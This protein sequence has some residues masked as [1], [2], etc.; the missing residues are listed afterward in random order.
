M[1]FFGHQQ[2]MLIATRGDEAV[3]LDTERSDQ[4]RINLNGQMMETHRFLLADEN[5]LPMY[6]LDASE[7]RM[8]VL[9]YEISGFLSRTLRPLECFCRR[10]QSISEWH[11]GPKM[12]G[13][14]GQR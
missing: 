1:H 14:D 5:W 11:N 3:A 13:S 10:R 7:A 6:L 9:Q 8:R 4:R 12:S 2:R